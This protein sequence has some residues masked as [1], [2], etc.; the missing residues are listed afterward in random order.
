LATQSLLARIDDPDL[1]VLAGPVLDGLDA[2]INEIRT[3]VFDCRART[4]EPGRR[5]HHQIE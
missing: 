4:T 3:T 2:A 5:Q 1:A